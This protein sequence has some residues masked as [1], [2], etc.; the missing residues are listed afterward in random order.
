VTGVTSRRPLRPALLILVTTLAVALTLLWLRGAFWT[1]ESWVYTRRGSIAT[2]RPS[3]RWAVDSGGG[4]F[5]LWHTTA[6]PLPEDATPPPDTLFYSAEFDLHSSPRFRWDQV[7]AAQ[8]P[9]R[10]EPQRDT[11]AYLLGFED[12]RVHLPT[13][14]I[15]AWAMPA[16][17]VVLLLWLPFTVFITRRVLRRRPSRGFDMAPVD[18]ASGAGEGSKT[19]AADS[20]KPLE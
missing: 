2:G 11:L 10:M 13:A 3:V 9:S 12:Y 20:I 19:V 18:P 4:R 6:A 8:V 1:A 15:R 14:E 7:P 5:F 17:P 16:W